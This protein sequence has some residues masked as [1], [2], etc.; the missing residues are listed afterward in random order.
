VSARRGSRDSGQLH[1]G[2]FLGLVAPSRPLPKG[3]RRVRHPARP[4]VGTGWTPVRFRA[5]P[6]KKMTQR[7]TTE[8]WCVYI[9]LCSDGS[10]YTGV[11]TDI[12][13]RLKQHNSGKGSKYVRS[14]APAHV[15]WQHLAKN[16]SNALQI[17]SRIKKLP[18][19][20][21][22]ELVENKVRLDNIIDC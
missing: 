17:E 14:R 22:R 2:A 13:R 10:L 9:L 19:R 5:L 3:Q 7:C 12:Y 8:Q 15:V 20:S 1:I 18:T 4:H 16:R 6:L 21:K 11:T